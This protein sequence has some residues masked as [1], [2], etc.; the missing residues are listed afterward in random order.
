MRRRHLL[1]AASPALTFLAVSVS[2]ALVDRLRY[3][4]N[5]LWNP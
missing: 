5:P 4:R 1:L 3:A 2:W